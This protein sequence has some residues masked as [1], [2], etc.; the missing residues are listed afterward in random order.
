M[1][2]CG[3]EIQRITSKVNTPAGK[4][5]T[6]NTES[7]FTCT[8]P[9]F[10]TED[11]HRQQHCWCKQNVRMLRNTENISVSCC[12]VESRVSNYLGAMENIFGVRQYA[13]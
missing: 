9:Y 12:H 6:E 10:M 1:D 2:K 4:Y 7:G 13:I 8:E 5:A 11:L 3:L